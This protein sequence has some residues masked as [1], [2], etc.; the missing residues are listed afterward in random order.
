MLFRSAL[1]KGRTTALDKV[2]KIIESERC[3]EV[4]AKGNRYTNQVHIVTYNH[5]LDTILSHLKEMR[6]K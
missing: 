4:D 1:E 2:E 5:A 3:S 6:T